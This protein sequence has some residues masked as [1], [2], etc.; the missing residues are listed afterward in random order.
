MKKIGK[1][2]LILLLLVYFIAATG[3][4]SYYVYNEIFPILAG[5]EKED[6]DQEASENDDES[7]D[8]MELGESFFE[9]VNVE[10]VMKTEDQRYYVKDQVLLMVEEDMDEEVVI[11]LV[12][13]YGGEVIGFVEF[14]NLYQLKVE[15]DDIEALNAMILA[16]ETAEGVEAILPVEVMT[17]QESVGKDC[18][19][20][21]DELFTRDD[22]ARHYEMIGM[23]NAWKIM[24]ASGLEMQAVQV[25]VLD[26]YIYT[27]STEINGAVP[28]D[29]D[30]SDEPDRDDNGNV[31]D[32]GLTHG[33]QVTH[34][35]A[36]D[37]SNDGVVG[38]ASV[39]GSNMT[40]DVKNLF[41][42]ENP[43]QF[44]DAD[45]ILTTP[46][47]STVLKE[48]IYLKELISKGATVINCSFGQRNTTIN[49]PE[50]KAVWDKFLEKIEKE[51]PEVVIVGSAGN[52][53][54]NH[55]ILNGQNHFPGGIP[56]DN[57]ISV[58]SVTVD[59]NKSDFSNYQ[60]NGGEVT[61]SAPA[62]S[63]TVAKDS[64]GNP[65]Q[66]SGTSFAAPQV[67]A[68]IALL[69]SINPELTAKE[70]K[71]IL[72]NS[73]STSITY[74]GVQTAYPANLGA[75]VLNVEQA[76]LKVVNLEREKQGLPARTLEDFLAYM[77]VEASAT[78]GD[79]GYVIKAKVPKCDGSIDLV[80][81]IE[82]DHDLGD[83]EYSQTVTE[84]QEVSWTV[85]LPANSETKTK[86]TIERDDTYGCSRFQLPD[87]DFEGTWDVKM[88]ILED[89][90]TPILAEML[91]EMFEGMAEEMG[92][93]VSESG[94]VTQNPEGLNSILIIKKTDDSGKNFTLE[95]Q[96]KDA[97]SEDLTTSL[98]EIGAINGS[99]DS[100]GKLNFVSDQVQ[101]GATIHFE[102]SF[103]IVDD[104]TIDGTMNFY[105]IGSEEGFSL[106]AANNIL[107]SL[108]GKRV[109][110]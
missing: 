36:A 72:K 3:V 82:G 52:N 84:G 78:S 54:I 74:N 108:I 59:G 18:T 26:S 81:K 1:I 30:F 38:I 88:T 80:I 60:G 110:Q 49:R 37:S 94:E 109:T 61:L 41:D 100:N 90:L 39:L 42:N 83:Q 14:I 57:V 44:V 43:M 86:I 105:I 28:I 77:K 19:P 48:I 16:L 92:C 63:M 40:I 58:G 107:A 65:L 11:E 106:T 12:A 62:S 46:N 102:Y 29:G 32:E 68:T 5:E 103:G 71:D 25:G 69:K 51:H 64:A 17:L 8:G 96:S 23:T 98:Q 34:I 99:V 50:Q 93:T 79:D 45:A 75:G 7:E 73:A 95:M 101:E 6:E 15:A 55:G 56:A 91:G 53:G 20:Y 21:N 66:N 9:D 87:G 13:D 85:V 97:E 70:I 47:Y 22:V 10:A 24:K 35:I 89:N 33:T 67:T 76:V 104:Q 2:L 27:G 31:S 4:I